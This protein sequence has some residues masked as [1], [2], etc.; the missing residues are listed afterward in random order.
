MIRFI[1]KFII[2]AL[3]S[4][5]CISFGAWLL[6]RGS[7]PTLD[8]TLKIPALALPVT[9]E[10]D[11]LG[12]VTIRGENRAD[13]TWTLGYIHAQERFFEMDLM[14]RSASGELAELFGGAALPI[15]R[16]ARAHRMRARAEAELAN[17]PAADR[18]LIARYLADIGVTVVFGVISIVMRAAPIG[19]FG[20]MA[21]TVGKY[22]LA[23]LGSLAKLMGAFYA[24]SLIFVFVV[25][26]GVCAL[27]GL[28]IFKLLRYLREEL[29]VLW[30]HR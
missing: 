9:V 28:S 4:I 19:A 2:L 17:A 20:A 6:L 8:G 12:T 1:R 25:L 27:L 5:I 10:R 29:V 13:V 16:R 15:D 18:D 14:R 11:S 3:I 30:A 24:T 22:G 21:Y 23:S 7:L 26:G